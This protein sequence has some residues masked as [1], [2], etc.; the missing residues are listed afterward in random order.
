MNSQG[1]VE[2]TAQIEALQAEIDRLHAK[3]RESDE[4]VQAIQYGEVDAVVVRPSKRAEDHAV[5]TFYGEDH[6]YRV[7]VESMR[8]GAVTMARDGTVLYC[9]PSFARMMRSE[10]DRIVGDSFT[11]FVDPN[12]DARFHSFLTQQGG[13]KAEMALTAEDGTRVPVYLSRSAADLVGMRGIC[14]VVTDLTSQ[15]RHEE[16]IASER[17][18]RSILEQAAEVIVVC[19]DEGRITHASRPAALLCGQ[20]PL[21]KRFDEIF[22]C[23]LAREESTRGE[24]GEGET[25]LSEDVS[26]F[27]RLACGHEA[28]NGCEVMLEREGGEV[29]H[30]LLSS[31]PLKGE[32]G[33][34]LGAVLILADVTA[35]RRAAAAI[36]ES[37][38]KLRIANETLERRVAERTVELSRANRVLAQKNRDLQDFAYMA[39]HDLQEPLRKITSFLD[40]LVTEVAD[41]L[42][43]DSR[44]YLERTK[45]AAVRMSN[46]IRDLLDFSRVSTHG[47]AARPV[48]LN[49]VVADVLADLELSIHEAQAEIIVEDLPT[50]SV[51]PVQIYQLLHNLV[52]NAVKFRKADVPAVIHLRAHQDDPARPVGS[53]GYQPMVRLEIEDNGIGF[54]VKYADRIFS[55]F[56]RLHGRTSYEG[57]GMGLAICRRIVERHHGSLTARSTPGVGSTF[58]VALP[59]TPA[60]EAP[61]RLGGQ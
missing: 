55:P 45:A 14:L 18:A 11:R 17:L 10:A 22:R 30:L 28:I 54:D 51:D 61:P 42:K 37:E 24:G 41:E 35:P 36:R 9:N 47:G 26:F 33:R 16:V 53:D 27:R 12:D 5:Y 49:A 46:L 48:D 44:F 20:N 58:V 3:Y 59:L 7:L 32:Q 52:S 50:I 29:V 23:A 39:S 40:L 31:A 43:E 1:E 4:I 15:K 57:T 19:N 60:G 56:Q 2:L 34:V 8:E 13:D 6:H 38:R 21:L 25:D